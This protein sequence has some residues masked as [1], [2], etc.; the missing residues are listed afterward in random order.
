[1]YIKC[2]VAP[3]DEK[4]KV[5]K[6]TCILQMDIGSETNADSLKGLN[7]SLSLGLTNSCKCK[8]QKWKALTQK[9]E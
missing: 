2:H 9:H 8:S 1:M 3:V 4:M 6:K 5:N 7:V